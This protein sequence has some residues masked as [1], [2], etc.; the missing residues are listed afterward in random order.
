METVTTVSMAR[1][2]C[3]RCGICYHTSDGGM[4]ENKGFVC[5]GCMT[6]AESNQA[7]KR[8]FVNWKRSTYR[9]LQESV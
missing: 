4:F 5:E 1:M 8:N 6:H 3:E 9:T 7:N 2:K